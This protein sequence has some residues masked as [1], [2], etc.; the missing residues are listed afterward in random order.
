MAKAHIEAYNGSPAL[1]IDG[2]PFP[3]MAMTVPID[4]PDY[5]KAIGETGIKLFFVSSK[6]AWNEPAREAGSVSGNGW[7]GGSIAVP[8]DDGLSKTVT[9]LTALLEAV[10]DAYVIL[11]LCVAPSVEWTNSHPEEQVRFNDGRTRETD[12]FGR[13][14]GMYSLCSEAWRRDGSAAIRDY[15][16]GLGKT[17]VFDR[18]IGFFLTAGGT[19]EWYYPGGANGPDGTWGDFSESFRK[20][21]ESYLRRTYGSVEKLRRA[22]KRE[23]ADFEHPIIPNAAERAFVFDSDARIVRSL[24]FEGVE[25]KPNENTSANIGVFLNANTAL[26]TADFYHAWNDGTAQ[27]ILCFARVLKECCPDRVVGAFYGSFGCTDYCD[28]STCT[29]ILQLEQSG[30]IDFL[31]APG[32]YSNREPGGITAQRE[33]HDS[34]RLNHM[35]YICEDD[36][37]THLVPDWRH[38]EGMGLYSL[39]DTLNTLKRDFGRNICEDLYGW[40]FD[41]EGMW[42]NDPDILSLF[43]R[44]QEISAASFRRDRTKKNEIAL[45]YDTESVHF[46]SHRTAL[47]ATEFFRTTELERIGAPVDYYFHNDMSLAEMPD[48]K[49]YVM[50]NTYTLTARERDAIHEKARRNHAVVLWLYAPGFIDPEADHVM[51][52]RHAEKTVGMKLRCVTETFYPYFR[53]EKESHPCLSMAK[54][55]RRYGALDRK[56]HCNLLPFPSQL[57]PAYLNPGFLVDDPEAVVLGRFLG[58]GGPAMALKELDGFTSI[59]CS[60]QI[61]QSDLLASIAKYAGV[62]LFSARDDV[63]FA[64]ENFVTVHAADDGVRTIV[65]KEP[66]SPYEVYEKRYYGHMVTEI[67]L[68]MTLGETKMWSLFGEC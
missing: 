20:A 53:V 17:A 55:G 27:T 30:L 48:Y 28:S 18:V 4:D 44:Q 6:M 34:L 65:F 3:P 10:P 25:E 29:G 61:L 58:N 68:D 60:T 41:M 35:L 66:C 31:S 22:W 38:R 67:S 13:L 62:H 59:F 43:Q 46:V 54:N 12:C 26:H 39:A 64:N 51:D 5:L 50:I 36:A 63:L 15:L 19:D 40:W 47:V 33:M 42:Y 2:V 8:W 52:V 32:T 16:N 24:M 56:L 1:M 45:I 7:L 23:D 37:R 21:Y 14:D 57:P 49:L 9:N 11:R